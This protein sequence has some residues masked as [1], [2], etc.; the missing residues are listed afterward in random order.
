V[1]AAR[2]MERRLDELELRLELAALAEDP[3]ARSRLVA[4]IQ[5][6]ASEAGLAPFGGVAPRR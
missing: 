3:G 6:E 4:E 5:R 1:D 2:R